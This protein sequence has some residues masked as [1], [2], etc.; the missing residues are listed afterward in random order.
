VAVVV[1]VGARLVARLQ[2]DKAR[3]E[4]TSKRYFILFIDIYLE[5]YVDY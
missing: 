4:L 2:A 5:R 1:T 3:I